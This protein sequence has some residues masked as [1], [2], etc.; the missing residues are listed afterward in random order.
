MRGTSAR[1]VVAMLVVIPLAA[2]S[3]VTTA[4]AAGIESRGAIQTQ[5]P[6]E[7]PGTYQLV[8]LDGHELPYV[9]SHDGQPGPTIVSGSLA[10]GKDG[11]VV[12]TIGFSINGQAMS[13]EVKGTYTKDGSTLTV[14][15]EQAG[16]TTIAVDGPR[17][18]MDN[19]GTRFAY[20]KS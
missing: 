16:R 2:L 11:S 9:L 5:A 19:E 4:A 7:L 14:S 13:R 20:R 18:S 12:S 1:G 8:A 15:W 10:I 6:M 17:L 3:P